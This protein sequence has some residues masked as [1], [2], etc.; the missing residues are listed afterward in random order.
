MFEKAEYQ[1]LPNLAKN[2]QKFPQVSLSSSSLPCLQP[3]WVLILGSPPPLTPE[4]SGVPLSPKKGPSSSSLSSSHYHLTTRISTL[5]LNEELE[6]K[7]TSLCLSK[8]FGITA[9]VS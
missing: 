7:V 5:L 2:R 4:P 9:L 1:V 8:A 6:M 3:S